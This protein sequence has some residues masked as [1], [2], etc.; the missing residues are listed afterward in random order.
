MEILVSKEASQDFLQAHK[1]NDKYR[2]ELAEILHAGAKQQ[3]S[4][5]FHDSW[6]LETAAKVGYNNAID[7]LIDFLNKDLD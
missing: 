1:Y 3:I 7:A 4:T 5:K 6:D 2:S